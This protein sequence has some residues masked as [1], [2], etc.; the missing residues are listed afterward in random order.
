MN[1][2]VQPGVVATTVGRV[3]Y[4]DLLTV[5]VTSL[6]FAVASLPVVTLG[7]AVLALVETW[8]TVLTR[9]NSGAPPTEWGRARLFVAAF[10]RHLLTGL[11]YSLLLVAVASLTALYYLVGV[12]RGSALFLLAALAGLYVV[13]VAV[14]WVLRAASFRARADPSLGVRRSVGRAGETFVDH[15]S[16]AVLLAASVGVV[17]LAASAARITVVVLLPGVLA[18]V[19]VVA[20]EEVAG[21]GAAAIRSAYRRE[22]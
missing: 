22:H 18:A 3:L 10:R 11:P 2:E 16:F 7:A 13:V 21:D 5:V 6:L 17:L 1:S 19:E 9:R 12:A 15:P 4:T 8:T 20:F 14:M